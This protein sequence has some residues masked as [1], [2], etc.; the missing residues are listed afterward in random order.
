MTTVIF[1]HSTDILIALILL[2]PVCV[3]QLAYYWI[4]FSRLAFYRI[5]KVSD[6]KPAV[7]IVLTANNQYAYLY[8]YLPV[9]LDQDYPD[10]E[11][12]VVNDN[13]DDGTEDLLKEL[14]R[15]FDNLKSIA[16]RQS[17]NWFKGRKFPLSLGIK[18]A[19][20]DIIVLIDAAC[21]PESKNWISEITTA[22][23]NKVEIVLG[24]TTF[25]TPSFINRFLRFTAFYDALVYLSLALSGIPFKGIGKNLSYK[26]EL[27]YRHKGFSSHY[28]ISAGDD[29]IFV[30]KTANSKNTAIC[31]SKDS[32]VKSTTKVSFFKWLQHEKSRLNIRKYFK[33]GHRFLISLFSASTFLFYGLFIYLLVAGVPWFIPVSVFGLRL[34]SQVIIFGLVQKKLSE[35]KLLLFSPLFEIVIVAI[36]F[37]IWLVLL[38]AKRSKWA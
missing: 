24:Y 14:S 20:N 15:Q 36:D 30:N 10:F 5:K 3:I 6:E 23:Q 17:L 19:R 27:F 9:L 8:K 34:I 12:L 2:I 1:D 38:F 21:R 11:V 28:T 29:E 7:S 33:T 25:E 18:S 32:I 31:I 35:K 37:I 4:F 13:S 26:R 22:Y 16:L